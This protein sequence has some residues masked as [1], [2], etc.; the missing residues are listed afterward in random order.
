MRVIMS[1]TLQPD[2]WYACELIGDEF[3][4]DKCSYSPIKVRSVTALHTGKRTFRLAF[5]HASYPEGVQNKEYT[6]RTLERGRSFILAKSMAHD[7]TRLLLVY[8]IDGDW[9]RRHCPGYGLADGD[10]QGYLDQHA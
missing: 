10:V 1:F 3:D 5:Y 8:E 6:L 4:Q 7:P 9:L 2:R